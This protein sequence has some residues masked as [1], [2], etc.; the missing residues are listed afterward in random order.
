MFCNN[1][2]GF[3]VT[4]IPNSQAFPLRAPTSDLVSN[5]R[6]GTVSMLKR[7]CLLHTFVLSTRVFVYVTETSS[8]SGHVFPF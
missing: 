5:I 8:C 2:V 1:G 6:P 7:V 3:P 4:F